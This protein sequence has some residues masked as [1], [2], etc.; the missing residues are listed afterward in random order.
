MKQIGKAI[1]EC[2]SLR[3]EF[4]KTAVKAAQ[5]EADFLRSAIE[6]CE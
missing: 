5:Y 4:K 1:F 6:E 2:R 3:S